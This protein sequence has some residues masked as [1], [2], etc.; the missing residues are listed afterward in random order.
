MT[1]QLRWG[2]HAPSRA[3]VGALTDHTGAFERV[4]GWC[5]YGALIRP[6]GRRSAH[7]RARALPNS[8][9]ILMAERSPFRGDWGKPRLERHMNCIAFA[10]RSEI[11]SPNL[12]LRTVSKRHVCAAELCP[13]RLV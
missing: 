5:P 13:P 6:A 3:V 7:A 11:K 10:E 9:C 4:T 2:A 1:I 8:D 12:D